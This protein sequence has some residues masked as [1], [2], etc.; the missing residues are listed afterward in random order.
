MLTSS[1]LDVIKT[2]DERVLKASKS[3]FGICI[4]MD[5]FSFTR[6]SC[7]KCFNLLLVC[8]NL[9]FEFLM[10]QAPVQNRH[11]FLSV[12]TAIFF[13]ERTILNERKTF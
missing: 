7:G 1:N 6:T 5:A 2:M 4:N 3:V 9:T 13:P 12:Q 11:V 8:W 10:F